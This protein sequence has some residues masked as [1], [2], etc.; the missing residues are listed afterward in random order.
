[1]NLNGPNYARIQGKDVCLYPNGRLISFESVTSQVLY[2]TRRHHWES[3][4]RKKCIKSAERFPAHVS[5][6][7]GKLSDG[8]YI[9]FRGLQF[10]QR[11]IQPTKV[12]PY[13]IHYQKIL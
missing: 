9:F 10:C 13:I 7:L 8:S 12:Y 5:A 2:F 6:V 3:S 1:M 11:P 4:S